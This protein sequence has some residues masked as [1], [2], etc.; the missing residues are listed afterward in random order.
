[1][2]REG[3][4]FT[5]PL[6]PMTLSCPS[7]Q[8]TWN[9]R[10]SCPSLAAGSVSFSV[11]KFFLLSNFSPCCCSVALISSLLFLGNLWVDL[12]SVLTGDYAWGG[13]PRLGVV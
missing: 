2:P 6:P 1:M 5:A 10:N 7:G 13:G 12:L 4:S 9:G 3:G 11:G 8:G